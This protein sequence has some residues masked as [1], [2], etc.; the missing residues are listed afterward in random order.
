MRM[1]KEESNFFHLNFAYSKESIVFQS[2]F[3]SRLI[4]LSRSIPQIEQRKEASF[5]QFLLFTSLAGG[6]DWD[7]ALG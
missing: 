6:I 1:S 5:I 4:T 7:G 3:V 2:T